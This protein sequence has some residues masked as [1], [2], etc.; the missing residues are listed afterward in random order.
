MKFN[1]LVTGST[2]EMSANRVK[3]IIRDL[4]RQGVPSSA[5]TRPAPRGTWHSKQSRSIL[6][7]LA[8]YGAYYSAEGIT[9]EVM[10]GHIACIG[11]HTYV[12]L[13][14]SDEAGHLQ[15]IGLQPKRANNLRPPLYGLTPSGIEHAQGWVTSILNGHLVAV[16]LAGKPNAEGIKQRLGTFPGVVTP[17]LLNDPVPYT[18]AA[19][20]L[21]LCW[22]YEQ[23]SD[24]HAKIFD[25]PL[26]T[27]SIDSYSILEQLANKGWVE[28]DSSD[29]HI[30]RPGKTQYRLTHAGKLRA[31]SYIST[32]LL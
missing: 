30:R 27:K 5:L 17:S 13:R 23:N 4:A 3:R 20:M 2:P 29:F 14:I 18:T 12:H 25:E 24:I 26:G 6:W 16:D 31:R 22:V 11:R 19:L 28:S 9:A 10:C 32:L 1:I 15:I 21:I 8:L 7:S